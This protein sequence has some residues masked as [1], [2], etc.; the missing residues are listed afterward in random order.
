M[1]GS[2]RGKDKCLFANERGDKTFCTVY[3]CLT[4]FFTRY[5]TCLETCCLSAALCCTIN[6][7]VSNGGL[8]RSLLGVP[9]EERTGH[10]VF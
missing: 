6:A 3:S 1:F 4:T 2:H 9:L 7:R 10:E 5:H 8:F